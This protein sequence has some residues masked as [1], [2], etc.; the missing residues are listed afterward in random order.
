MFPAWADFTAAITREMNAAHRR[1]DPAS[2]AAYADLLKLANGQSLGRDVPWAAMAA[3]IDASLAALTR[4]G[5]TLDP[6]H[7]AAF[8]AHRAQ[9]SVLAQQIAAFENMNANLRQLGKHA[10]ITAQ[11]NTAGRR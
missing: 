8:R 1:A 3:A 9:I 5:E 2:A 6:A 4:A 7:T 10:A 11:K